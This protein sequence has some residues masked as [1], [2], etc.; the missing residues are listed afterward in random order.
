MPLALN[1]KGRENRYSLGFQLIKCKI[2]SMKKKNEKKLKVS[3]SVMKL[4]EE[5][6]RLHR[7]C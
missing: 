5:E 6:L 3:Q 2:L 4:F 1:I 7:V